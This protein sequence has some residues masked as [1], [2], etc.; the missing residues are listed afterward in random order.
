MT[1]LTTKTEDS[2]VLNRTGGLREALNDD[3]MFDEW[4]RSDLSGSRFAA[5]SRIAATDVLWQSEE[6]YS[7]VT[8]WTER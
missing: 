2:Y 7:N 1:N 6:A 5:G 4:V 8:A 3:V